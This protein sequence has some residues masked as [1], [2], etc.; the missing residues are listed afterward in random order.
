MAS[1]GSLDVGCGTFSYNIAT[2]KDPDK[3]K[4][5]ND[6]SP[7]SN[8]PWF[9]I[10]YV[11]NADTK[12]YGWEAAVGD[13]GQK[14]DTCGKQVHFYQNDGFNYAHTSYKPDFKDW[15]N[16]PVANAG[17]IISIGGKEWKSCLYLMKNMSCGS[18][19]TTKVYKC[20][21]KKPDPLSITCKPGDGNGFNKQTVTKAIQVVCYRS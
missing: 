8:D 5:T 10:M 18:G 14:L 9:V 13:K 21:K 15:D 3:D 2:D 4:S 20:E 19:Y 6:W 17:Q 16:L 11:Y 7:S 12:S 1:S